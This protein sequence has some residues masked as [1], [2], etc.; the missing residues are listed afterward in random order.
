MLVACEQVKT[1][2]GC[3]GERLGKTSQIEHGKPVQARCPCH[4]MRIAPRFRSL[5]TRFN[6]ECVLPDE[7]LVDNWPVISMG[8][9][10]FVMERA[11]KK[12]KPRCVH[13]RI[14]DARPVVTVCA[15]EED[16]LVGYAHLQ[17]TIANLL[18]GWIEVRAS[19]VG[20][21]L[22]PD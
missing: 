12:W 9:A 4:A 20:G 16:S 5:R 7:P 13:A 18:A 11:G 22:M 21:A 15:Y 6:E 1:K 8:K 17:V 3:C 19:K 14:V 2:E 10:K